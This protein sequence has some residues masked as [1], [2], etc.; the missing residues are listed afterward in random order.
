MFNN[1]PRYWPVMMVA[2]LLTLTA[3]GKK[4]EVLVVTPLTDTSGPLRYVPADTP[5]VLSALEPAPDDFMDK[6]EPKIDELLVTYRTMLRA[7]MAQAAD[8]AADGES[9]PELDARIAA[10]VEELVTLLSL[11]GLRGAGMSRDSTAVFYGHGLLPVLRISLTDDALLDAAIRRIETEAGQS[12]PVG[13]IQGRQ[14][15]YFDAEQVR[16]ILA[17]LDDQMI[18]T[19]V[20]P[21]FD[22]AQ[23][24]QL[25]GLRLPA[26]NIAE[27]GVLQEIADEYGFMTA[28]VG[29]F[30]TE[31][32]AATFID[33]PAGLNKGLL[34]VIGHDVNELS[35]I[36]KAEIR[37]LAAVAPRIVSG[38]DEISVEQVKSS[39]VVE[40]RQD[41]AAGMATIPTAVPGLGTPHGGLFSIGL[42]MNLTATREFLASRLDALE[43]E[44]FE[45]DK[46]AG[47]EQMVVGGRQALSQPLPPVAY[48]FRGFVAVIN[49]I[50]GYDFAQ[51]APPESIEA[52]FLLAMDD[53]PALLAFGQM[54]SPE[55]AEMSIE[56][57][58]QPHQLE[59]PAAQNGIDSAWIALSESALALS[60]SPEAE[61]VLPKLLQA[62]SVSPPP[63]LSI[64]VD[65]ESYYT[66]VAQAMEKRDD[67]VNEEMQAAIAEVLV[68]AAQFYDRFGVRVDFTDRGIEVSSDV[69]LA[70]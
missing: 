11:D 2:V 66:M 52:S 36:C 4:D 15:R 68:A 27:T 17:T 40:L 1:A 22:E 46:L 41:I 23:L 29:F 47:F 56:P 39:L 3:C 26:R 48:N 67:D 62:D 9:D 35:D 5:Y 8:A 18:L 24:D 20:P 60:V 43:A 14:Y 55:L 70:D 37:S 49:D 25:L 30:S 16:V 53:A 50:Q 38:Y 57:D 64:D 21:S 6:M 58:S 33:E 54:M 13:E 61:N 63:F 10:V 45:C 51:Q 69:T 42:S 32:L 7:I 65:A 59:L 31:R 12:L 44:P 19:V 28:F 34:A